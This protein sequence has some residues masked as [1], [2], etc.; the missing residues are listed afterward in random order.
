GGLTHRITSFF[1]AQRLPVYSFCPVIVKMCPVAGHLC[2][3]W[4]CCTVSVVVESQ[5]RSAMVERLAKPK[6]STAAPSDLVSVKVRMKESQRR[7]YRDEAERDGVSINQA[8]ERRLNRTLADDA[9]EKT[10]KRTA[11]VVVA[12]S[13]LMI[14]DIITKNLRDLEGRIGGH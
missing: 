10:I 8:I 5:G 12:Q 11:E 1:A 9:M 13:C 3:V 6:K 14:D 4:F 7:I 2:P